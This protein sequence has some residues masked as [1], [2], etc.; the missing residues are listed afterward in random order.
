MR[1]KVDGTQH[2]DGRVER[3]EVL[4]DDLTWPTPRGTGC[5]VRNFA[6]RQREV[7]GAIVDV[8]GVPGVAWAN[9]GRLK[10]AWA[11]KYA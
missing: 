5:A 11:V 4:D 8:A 3:F 10:F 7:A 2:A 9:G 1:L 6:A